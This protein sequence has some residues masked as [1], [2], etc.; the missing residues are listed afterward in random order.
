MPSSASE[1]RSES[2][3]RSYERAESIVFL[4]TKEAFG[5]LSNMAGGFPLRVNDIHIFTSEA[6]YQACRFPHLPDVQKLV[7]SEA[8]PMTAKMKTKPYRKDSRPDWDQ[9]RVRIMRWCLRVKLAQNWKAFGELLLET[10]NKSIVEESYK[11]DFWGAKPVDQNTLV[12][13]NV[14]GRLLMELREELKSERRDNL[15]EVEPLPIPDFLLMGQPIQ[16]VEAFAIGSKRKVAQTSLF[17]QPMHSVKD[18][19][20]PAYVNTGTAIKGFCAYP[21]YKDSGLPWLGRVPGHWD[22]LPHRALFE[23]VKVREHPNE[24][25]LSVT[26]TRGVIKQRD[27]LAGSSKKD[28]SKLDKSAYK[29]VCPGDI[30]YNKMRA[31]QGAIGVSDLRGIISPAYVV[32]RMRGTH[33][34]RYFHHLFRT[35]GF[36]KEAESWSYGITSDMWSLR[37][38]HFKAIYSPLPPADEQAAIVRYLDHA[39]LRLDK[40][41]RAKRKTIALLNEQKQAIIHRAVTRGLDPAVKLKD[42][43]IPWLGQIPAHWDVRKLKFEMSFRG[44]GTPSKG[45]SAYWNGSIPWVSPKDMKSEIIHDAEDHITERAVAE[46]STN[47]VPAGS[48]LMVVRS[49]ILKRAI[50]VARCICEVALNQ[51]MKALTSKGGLDLDYFVLFIRGCEKQLLR[52]WTKQGA[53]VESV[54]HQYLAN[55][56]VPIPPFLEQQ[57]I[58]EQLAVATIPLATTISRIE[59][60]IS[61]LR[62]YRTRLIADVVTGKL[63][64]REAAARLPNEVPADEPELASQEEADNEMAEE[65]A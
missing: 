47:L 10:G 56:K 64:V 51:D 35:P 57:Q 25:M 41:I 6:L 36:A 26:I 16:T 54:E 59:R 21:E 58:V 15:L 27:L 13:M 40:A 31:W 34:P 42:S 39:L 63:D 23:E 4:K 48:L 37:P 44:G 3:V 43:G 61:L 8:S 60:E 22:V 14:L 55:T 62:E 2:Q 30:A 50:P 38:E 19:T 65:D 49:G 32:Q 9:V 29:L 24:Q 12:G 45:N 1:N 5:G 46:S 33:N 7:L 28:S 17:D 20:P 52:E 53:T 11:D 18:Q